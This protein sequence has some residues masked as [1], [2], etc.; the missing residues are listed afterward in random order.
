M[1][2]PP[3]LK[4]ASCLDWRAGRTAPIR[5]AVMK[6]LLLILLAI[7]EGWEPI[8]SPHLRSHLRDTTYIHL[9]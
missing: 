2:R 3:S 6:R 8:S 7:E 5:R 1:N 4:S 9:S